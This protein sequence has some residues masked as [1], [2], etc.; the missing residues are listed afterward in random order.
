M[1]DPL[2]P[3]QETIQ[4]AATLIKQGQVVGFPTETV[5]GLGADAT[6]NEAVERIYSAKHRPP[7][8]PLIS[9]FTSMEEIQQFTVN[10][11][12]LAYQL[13]D[14]FWPGPLTMVLNKNEKISPLVTQGLDTLAVR[15]PA[16]PV[17]LALIAAAG[18]PIAAPSA[19]LS[20]KPSPTTAAHV[21]KDLAGIIPMILDGGSTAIGV[22]S[23]VINLTS[24]T[25]ILLRPG[26]LTIEELREVIPNLKVTSGTPSGTPLSPGMKYTHYSP[27][28]P[29]I[30]V[31]DGF[32]MDASAIDEIAHN[33]GSKPLILCTNPG[34]SHELPVLQLGA[35]FREIQVNLFACLRLLDDRDH[36]VG[37]FE[38]IEAVKEGFAVMNRVRKAAHQVI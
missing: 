24:S 30:L 21:Y 11:P 28:T 35:T 7:D 5:Y 22:E 16:H 20:G 4:Q 31:T 37:I 38:A 34:H 10:I 12:E 9:H 2:H 33:H 25:P 29:L 19:N 8:N 36:D 17:A 23:T 3:D 1:V 15:I 6:N 18:V 13:A 26:G 14:Q 32:G 27:T